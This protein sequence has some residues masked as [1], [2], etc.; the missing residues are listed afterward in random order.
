[1]GKKVP[2]ISPKSPP[3]MNLPYIC[4]ISPLYL[5]CNQAPEAVMTTVAADAGCD[6]EGL[7]CGEP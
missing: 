1:M 3:Y 4:P 5:P 7:R 2:H 6:D